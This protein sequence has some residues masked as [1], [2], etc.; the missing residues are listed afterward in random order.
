MNSYKIKPK[1]PEDD[2]VRFPEELAKESAEHLKKAGYDASVVDKYYVQVN[3][4]IDESELSRWGTIMNSRIIK[5]S[6]KGM[7]N[8]VEGTQY[9]D[10][11]I[12][13]TGM[14]IL[15]VEHIIN[16][17][18]GR[19]NQAV[20]TV[21]TS[22]GSTNHSQFSS[23]DWKE[24]KDSA[25]D[26]GNAITDVWITEVE[27]GSYVRN[28]HRPIKS[29]KGENEYL[30]TYTKRDMLYGNDTFTRTISGDNE[31]DAKERFFKI[32]G[33]HPE[34]KIDNIELVQSSRKITSARYIA[35]DPESGEVLGSADTYEEAVNE[36][37][38]DVT[39]TDSEVGD[40]QEES[41]LFSSWDNDTPR[42]E[43]WLAHDD[44]KQKNECPYERGTEEYEDWIDGWE[45]AYQEVN[46][47][48]KPIKSSISAAALEEQLDGQFWTRAEDFEDEVNDAGWDVEDVNNEYATISN[49]KGSQ[50]EVRFYD[51]G[52]GRSFTME[53]FKCIYCDEDDDY[54]IE[55]SNQLNGDKA[56]L[57][58][59]VSSVL[60]QSMTQEQAVKR[61]ALRNNCNQAFARNILSSAMEDT[62]LIQSGVMAIADDINK[63]FNIDGDIESWF[64]DYVPREGTAN[65][66]GGEIL[67]A[68]TQIRGRYYNDG[69]RIGIGMGKENVNPA[70]RYLIDKCVGWTE[71]SNIEEMLSGDS[72]INKY[73]N[74]YKERIED[75]E[76]S[77]EDYLR[78]NEDYFHTVNKDDMWDYKTEYDDYDSIDEIFI[79]D[80]DNNEYWLQGNGDGWH[81]YTINYSHQPKYHV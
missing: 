47:S 49:D 63:D 28:S 57:S 22:D 66:V 37:G 46:S 21:Q 48:R 1:F 75:C 42:G 64:T 41:G 81:C 55:S 20:L 68:F 15:D 72:D 54:E 9:D 59:I 33:N 19:G 3:G 6:Q 77:L 36:W 53:S 24:Y 80:N 60:T 56:F 34:I 32:M 70:A 26:A 65:T 27:G 40:G 30:I 13:T 35:T 2:G 71:V 74:S 29:A 62:S 17:I 4:D 50:Y 79:M 31:E 44:G 5:S 7:E 78:N 10:Y 69:D 76:Y 58:N 14:G 61:I 12:D 51:H 16:E 52:E 18:E 67:R 25:N 39:I 73:N 11:H 45:A 38:E 23:K 43:G 8:V